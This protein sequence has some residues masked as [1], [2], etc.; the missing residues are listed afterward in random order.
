MLS[1]NRD[2]DTLL[3]QYGPFAELFS[4]TDQAAPPHLTLLKLIDNIPQHDAIKTSLVRVQVA[5]SQ[6]NTEFWMHR[7]LIETPDWRAHIIAAVAILMLED[8]SPAYVEM[9]WAVVDNGSWVSPQTLVVLSIVDASFSEHCRI[10]IESDCKVTLPKSISTNDRQITMGPATDNARAGKNASAIVELCGNSAPPA[11]WVQKAVE[12]PNLI[13]I[14]SSDV[15]GSGH[16]AA[17]WKK[18]LCEKFMLRGV[19]LVPASMNKTDDDLFVRFCQFSFFHRNEPQPLIFDVNHEIY[20]KHGID[21]TALVHLD[22]IGLIHFNRTNGFKIKSIG[23]SFPCRY[24][25]QMFLLDGANEKDNEALVGV[26]QFTPTGKDL[27]KVCGAQKNTDFIEYVTKELSKQ[28]GIQ[29][30]KLL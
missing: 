24:F 5:V 30:V 27:S 1:I 22:T 21:A 28:N 14:I 7:L 10:R 23:K 9:L 26:A 17:E 13:S 15:D 6:G 16:I 11:D 3:E 25:D 4:D 20:V 19:R 2:G 18:A 29:S 12:N 8:V